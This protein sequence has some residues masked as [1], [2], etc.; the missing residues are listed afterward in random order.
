VWARAAPCKRAL[1][2]TATKVAHNIATVLKHRNI[3]FVVVA[4]MQHGD[5]KG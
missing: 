5:I 4:D 2:L 1:A 3:F